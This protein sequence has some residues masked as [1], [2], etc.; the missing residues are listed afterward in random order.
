MGLYFEIL[1]VETGRI[2]ERRG[3]I[4]R[5]AGIDQQWFDH[6]DALRVPLSMFTRCRNA[7]W[8]AHPK[9]NY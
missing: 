7:F 2:R 5:I 8:A 9:F 1:A 4:Q 3:R 6:A